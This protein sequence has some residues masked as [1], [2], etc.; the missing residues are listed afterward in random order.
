MLKTHVLCQHTGRFAIS[1]RLQELLCLLAQ[2]YVFAEGEE[3][4]EQFLGI[5]LSAKQIQ[6]VSEHYGQ[7]LEEQ[8]NLQGQGKAAAP[9]LPVKTPQEVV[10]G[11]IDGSMIF[12]R[13]QGWKEMKAGRLFKAGSC[14]AVQPQRNQVMQ[15]LYVCHL[16]GH[17]KFLQKLE[18][19][20]EPYPRKVFV[21][22]GAKW[23]WNWV[24]DCYPGAVQILDVYHALEKLGAYA[25]WQYEDPT[26]RREWLE[27]QK[28]LLL[29][30][31]A[32]Q[33]VSQLKDTHPTCKQARRAGQDV[34]HY[35]QSNLNRMHYDHYLEQGYMIGSG[36]IEAAHRSV[37]QQRL[38]LSGQRWSIRGAQQIVNLRA[39]KKSNQWDSVVDLIKMAA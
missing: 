25:G 37:I 27:R 30:G 31:G 11:M 16:G 24:E 10:Y 35:Y 17:K 6:R 18:A 12:T 19:Y 21:C 5:G 1:S 26:R 3:L 34:V 2:G 29:Q 13:E 33:I 4:L 22:D 38:K 23:I 9:V 15:S 14:V 36:A 32:A 20:A 8:F 39:C 7:A 28:Q